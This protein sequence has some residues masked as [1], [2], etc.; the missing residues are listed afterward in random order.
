MFSMTSTEVH[1]YARFPMHFICF[2][3]ISGPESLL[4]GPTEW[5][6]MLQLPQSWLD[7]MDE[8]ELPEED[9]LLTTL[10]V[11]CWAG[12]TGILDGV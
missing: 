12:G 8:V 2:L 7:A 4:S 5:G 11:G 3:Q 6:T 10:E 9:P 1:S